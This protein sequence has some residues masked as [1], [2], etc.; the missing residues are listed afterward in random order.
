M[1]LSQLCGRLTR[2]EAQR[3]PAVMAAVLRRVRE[4]SHTDLRAVLVTELTAVDRAMGDAIMEQL[5]DAELEVLM[6]P[7]AVR[8][9]ET[10]SDAALAALARGDS[11]TTRQFQRALR[12]LQHQGDVCP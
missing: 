8:L 11:A 10:L 12:A 9:M 3:R 1:S 4:C 7:H 6:G 2:L 5:T